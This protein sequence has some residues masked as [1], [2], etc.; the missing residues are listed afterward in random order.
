MV[1]V[2]RTNTFER[3]KR[4]QM[5]HRMEIRKLLK[6]RTQQKRRRLQEKMT[7]YKGKRMGKRIKSR[8]R[9][10][11]FCEVSIMLKFSSHMQN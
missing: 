11:C 10:R 9:L 8:I 5:L 6:I 4:P 7:Q 1:R 2:F 3:V